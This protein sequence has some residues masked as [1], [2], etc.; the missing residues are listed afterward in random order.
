MNA[1]IRYIVLAVCSFVFCSTSYCAEKPDVEAGQ[2]TVGPVQRTEFDDVISDIKNMNL[3]EDQRRA[4]EAT[5]YCLEILALI[6]PGIYPNMK[7]DKF[8]LERQYRKIASEDYNY[9]NF[10]EST[11]KLLK[12]I[13]KR[14]N[15]LR[16]S[17][18]DRELLD[19][20]YVQEKRSAWMRVL[21]QN[22]AVLLSGDWKQIVAS[23][24]QT[25]IYSTFNYLKIRSEI[26]TKYIIDDWELN[27]RDI[28]YD[29]IFTQTKMND[30]YQICKDNDIEYV[31]L[32]DIR[33]LL[34]EFNEIEALIGD[35]VRDEVWKPFNDY[36]EFYRIED[37][38]TRYKMYSTY[39][40][41]RGYLAW[42]A[43]GKDK[44]EEDR[45]E[46]MGCFKVYQELANYQLV[47]YNTVAIDVAMMQINLHLDGEMINRD[48]LLDQLVIIR[49][50]LN[51]TSLDYQ[52]T[53]FFCGQIYYLALEQYKIAADMFKSSEL[54]GYTMHQKEI[55]K[56]CKDFGDKIEEF[57]GSDKAARKMF[58][59]K[60]KA[61]NL[62]KEYTIGDFA[63]KDSDKNLHF[64]PKLDAEFLTRM[65]Y[66]K[67]KI[68]AGEDINVAGNNDLVDRIFKEASWP[69]ISPWEFLFCAA[70]VKEDLTKKRY[71]EEILPK[72]LKCEN[73]D[74]KDFFENNPD[75]KSY[76]VGKRT[77]PYE[78]KYLSYT[79]SGWGWWKT[80]HF[81]LK[82]PYQY[83]FL[84]DIS[85]SMKLMRG[86]EVVTSVLCDSE[87]LEKD[88]DNSIFL[89]LGFPLNEQKLIDERID[90][91]QFDFEYKFNSSP[92]RTQDREYILFKSAINFNLDGVLT[93][94]MGSSFYK[95][96][97]GRI[98]FEL[99][100][101][102]DL[103]NGSTTDVE[104]NR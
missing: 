69:Y 55:D 21:P 44:K 39:W 2:L 4:V 17:K 24:M 3:L 56:F 36:R 50:N 75:W 1:K 96:L 84:S 77:L 26:E 31:A 88:K 103:E 104:A 78:L 42:R 63:L 6:D 14:I 102:D 46:A 60:K 74:C 97:P 81:F 12:N 52:S 85:F 71:Y 5:H 11:V 61:C 91:I 27:K 23:T 79:T 7:L 100:G 80:H 16:I 53:C 18:G 22:M 82:L 41:Q 76:P 86:R 57:E 58:E 43:Y 65:A 47:K 95:T 99:T 92:L 98:T 54:T 40:Y 35:G 10:Q 59:E 70:Y 93:K 48:F 66:Y 25:L 34:E 28:E 37:N 83:A 49:K 32:S 29:S 30:L 45:R 90:G 15:D 64:L 38:V 94:P 8:E 68:N 20:L 89:C 72:V 87:T 19:K 67:S 62:N 13:I 101:L 9:G 33:V 51:Q 73:F